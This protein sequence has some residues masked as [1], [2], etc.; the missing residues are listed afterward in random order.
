MGAMGSSEGE[1]SPGGF[2][3]NRPFF[4][5]ARVRF[6]VAFLA[7]SNDISAIALSCG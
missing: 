3:S 6:S 2:K 5:F 4:S 7:A 1:I